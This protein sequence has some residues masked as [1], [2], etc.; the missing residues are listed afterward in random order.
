MPDVFSV[1]VFFTV[2]RETLEAAIVISVLLSIVDKIANAQLGGVSPSATP[3][4]PKEKQNIEGG[5]TDAPTSFPSSIDDASSD[6]GQRRNLLR[7]L[8]IQVCQRSPSPEHNV[9]DS[10]TKPRLPCPYIILVT[11]QIFIG[12]AAGLLIAL[13][14][15]VAFI[16][17][18]FTRASDLWIKFEELWEGI[19]SLVASTLIF[20][21]GI[22]TLGMSKA[23]AKWR[24]KLQNAFEGKGSGS[25]LPG[26]QVSLTRLH[27]SC[28]WS[29]QG[30]KVGFVGLALGH[31]PP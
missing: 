17:V 20:A 10:R 13:A 30:R 9:P 22:T 27:D 28:R 8:R 29:Y 26:G 1:P 19:F 14:I 23:G 18:W 3:P 21:V 16:A 31:C 6:G 7:K 15:G 12:S 5:P 11:R 25:R 4:E 24:V 2:F